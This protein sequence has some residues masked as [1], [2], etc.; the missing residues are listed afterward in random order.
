[1]KRHI[2]N[3]LAC[4]MLFACNQSPQTATSV[5]DAHLDNKQGDLGNGHI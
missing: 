1:M 3:V 5:S 2:L 4:L